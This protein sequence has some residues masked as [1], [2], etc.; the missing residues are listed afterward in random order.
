MKTLRNLIEKTC[1]EQS[2][3]LYIRVYDLTPRF[4]IYI[5]DDNLMTVQNYAYGRGEDTPTLLLKRKMKG[6]LFDFYATAA[7]HILEHSTGII[8]TTA[9]GK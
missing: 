7:Q 8:D 6:G 9:T 1:P 3:H 5:V 2:Q 4:N